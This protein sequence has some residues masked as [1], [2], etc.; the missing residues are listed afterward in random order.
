MIDG[1][2]KNEST[3]KE[4]DEADGMAVEKDADGESAD[5]VSAGAVRA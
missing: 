5:A 4:K 1:D 2:Q 3:D